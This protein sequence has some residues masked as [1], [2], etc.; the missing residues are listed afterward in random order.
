MASRKVV[1]RHAAPQAA[2]QIGQVDVKVASAA[3]VAAALALGG[4]AINT[5]QHQAVADVATPSLAAEVAKV[6]EVTTNLPAITVTKNANWSFS[7]RQV[8]LQVDQASAGEDLDVSTR[9]SAQVSADEAA[10]K[11]AEE[12]T[13]ARRAV[14]NNNAAAVS[15]SDGVD[16]EVKA[17]TAEEVSKG[18]GTTGAAVVAYAK[19]FIGV[20]YVAGGTTPAGWDCI[21]YARYVYRHFGIELPSSSWG[22]RYAGRQI[23]AS[24]ARP[25]DLLWWPGHVAIYLA[26]N[27]NIAAWNESWGTRIGQDY[28]PPIY[29]RVL[30]D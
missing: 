11:R 14:T 21:G 17:Y 15:V 16:V 27:V 8:S 23:S 18:A 28:D 22:A 29:L 20:P 9:T 10:A 19:Q 30:P 1:G 26:P 25:G 4:F 13:E 5:P 7:G 6:A 12:E 3:S 2:R 24:E